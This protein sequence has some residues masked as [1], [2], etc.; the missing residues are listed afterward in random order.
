MSIEIF[1]QNK[2]YITAFYTLRDC[3]AGRDCRFLYNVYGK[4]LL[5]STTVNSH[6]ECHFFS[7]FPLLFIEGILYCSGLQG[8]MLTAFVVSYVVCKIYKSTLFQS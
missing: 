3:N 2:L 6:S 5:T 1:T 8:I 4:Q 7:N